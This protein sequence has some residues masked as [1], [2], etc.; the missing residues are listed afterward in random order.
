M[1]LG[2]WLPKDSGLR[3]RLQAFEQ[4]AFKLPAAG[5]I[6]KLK[7]ELAEGKDQQESPAGPGMSFL[8]VVL[9]TT[10]SLR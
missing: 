9:P 4:E 6:E 10:C 2:E 1:L 5:Y 3:L 7:A 8:R